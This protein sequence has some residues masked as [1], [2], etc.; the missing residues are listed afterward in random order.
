ML[1]LEGLS[2]IDGWVLAAVAAKALGYG[3]ALVA[4]GGPLFLAAFTHESHELRLARSVRQVTAVAALVLLVVLALRF[5]IRSARISGMG[6]EGMTDP[7]MLGFVWDSPLGT[8]AIWR[9][10]GAALVLFVIVPARLV[11]VRVSLGLAVAGAVA[12]AVSY[13]QVGHSLGEPRWLL[14]SLLVV[15]LLA[16]AWWIGALPP[17]YRAAAGREGAALLHRFGSLATGVVGLLVVAGVAF[18]WWLSGSIA[19]LLGTAYGWTLI[20]KVGT[21]ALLLGLAAQ[22]KLRLVPA[23]ARGDR[24]AAAAL[25]RSIA[26]EVALV[27]AILVATAALTTVTTPPAR[28]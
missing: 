6:V 15:H 14:A 26:W 19:A 17:L 10:V 24:S 3:L 16:V 11:P 23:L 7:T 13:A 22:N 21:V 5:G 12:I 18:S 9:A 25:R 2:P 20:A 1:V 4:M 28:L 27:A 8:V